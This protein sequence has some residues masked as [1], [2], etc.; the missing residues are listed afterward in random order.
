VDDSRAV[1]RQD[2]AAARAENPQ[3]VEAFIAVQAFA[4]AEEG[5]APGAAG[6]RALIEEA[7]HFRKGYDAYVFNNLDE[8]L[9]LARATAHG[10]E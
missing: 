8:L 10:W 1:T 4:V 7:R 6:I 3:K 5:K 9:E 2:F